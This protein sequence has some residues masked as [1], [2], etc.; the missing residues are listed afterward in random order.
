MRDTFPAPFSR[1]S[2]SP[3]H[4]HAH[5][6][7]HTH[8]HQHTPPLST[9]PP[10]TRTDANLL[11]RVMRHTQWIIPRSPVVGGTS[12]ASVI[13]VSAMP[14]AEHRAPR[15]PCGCCRIYV[16]RAPGIAF[17]CSCFFVFSIV[18]LLVRVACV[19]L[20]APLRCDIDQQLFARARARLLRVAGGGGWDGYC[21]CERI[22]A[23][24]DGGAG[25][26]TGRQSVSGS[27]SRCLRLIVRCVRDDDV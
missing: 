24:N 20:R 10:G 25:R 2:S 15:P 9:Q 16:I 5:L 18:L 23:V 3:T 4:A 12:A 14:A 21:H 13:S 8:K 6:T 1:N 17:V 22:R 27:I 11:P 19:L 7:H 26:P